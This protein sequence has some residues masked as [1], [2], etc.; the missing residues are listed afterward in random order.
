MS[1]QLVRLLALGVLVL[2]YLFF[3]RVMRAVWAGVATPRN[4]LGWRSLLA[5]RGDGPPTATPPR[6][7]W[8]SSCA[9]R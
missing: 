8:R 1:E 7:H 2:L 6:S 5:L 4:H 3:F 9:R